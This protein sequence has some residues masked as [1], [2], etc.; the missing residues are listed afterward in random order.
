[1]EVSAAAAE[2]I[3]N[4]ANGYLALKLSFVNEVAA[5]TEELGVEVDEVLRGI[6]LDPRIGSTYMHPGLGFGGSCLPKE[7]QLLAVAGRRLG[8]PMHLARAV[9]QVNGEQQDG[10]VRKILREL[11]PR[12]ARVGLLGLSFKAG[13]DDLR[14]SPALY[15]ARQLLDHDH[16]VT[17][18]DPAVR[19]DKAEQA[20]PGI[21]VAK[22]PEEVFV[23]ADAIVIATEWPQFADIDLLTLSDRTARPVLFDGRNLLDPEQVRRAGFTY[24]GVGRRTRRG[25]RQV[26]QA[27]TA[28][29]D[30]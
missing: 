2:L 18:Y 14:G 21:N 10:F 20:A 11:P 19:E 28:P 24:Y 6:A 23:S 25:E 22:S 13:T 3:K 26:S 7:L 5:L 27:A 4:V 29:A 30:A 16:R 8:L 12:G 9:A 1:M 17:A 15:V